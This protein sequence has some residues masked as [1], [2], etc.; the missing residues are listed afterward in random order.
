[1][2]RGNCIGHLIYGSLALIVKENDG[3]IKSYVVVE[4]EIRQLLRLTITSKDRQIGQSTSCIG[5]IFSKIAY[6][7][8]TT[9]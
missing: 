3:S 9:G 8:Y 4:L 5:S 2:T 1:M 7:P 6:G